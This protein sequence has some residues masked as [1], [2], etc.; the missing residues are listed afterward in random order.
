V[1]SWLVIII[2]HAYLPDGHG[3]FSLSGFLALGNQL[4]VVLGI[5]LGV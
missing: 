5:G 3:S 4:E 1:L 2:S